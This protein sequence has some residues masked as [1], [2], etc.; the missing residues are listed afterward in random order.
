MAEDIPRDMSAGTLRT[1]MVPGL[2]MIAGMATS[3]TSIISAGKA[4][5]GGTETT[6]DGWAGGGSWVPIGIGTRGRSIHIP[7]RLFHPVKRP[8][9]GIGA[10]RTSNTIPMSVHAPRD[11]EPYH[12]KSLL[13]NMDH[14]IVHGHVIGGFVLTVR[15]DTAHRES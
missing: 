9:S 15:H 5:T 11:G 4:D 8:A 10:M 14:G 1:V 13:G 3:S 12:R 6:G 2:N 7:T